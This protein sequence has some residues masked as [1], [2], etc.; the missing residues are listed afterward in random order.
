MTAPRTLEPEFR[1]APA[2][3][4][5]EAA[6]APA[7]P[8]PSR[9]GRLFGVLL[10]VALV[11]AA[12]G[13]FAFRQLFPPPPLAPVVATAP[14][15]AP[16][17]AAAPAAPEILHPLAPP[18][19]APPLPALAES[20]GPFVD[21]LAAAVGRDAI[22]RWLVP[23][24]LIRRIVVAVDNLPRSAVPQK[25]SPAKP[26]P[27]TFAVAGSDAAH[28]IAEANAARY[29]PL[30]RAVEAIDAEKLVAAYRLWYPRFQDAYRE[31]GYPNGYFNDRVVA[32]IDSMLAAPVAPGELPVVQPKVLW[33]FA[34]PNLE[35]RP[36]GQKLMLRIG[37]DNAARVRAKLAAIRRLIA[38]DAP[39]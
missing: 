12:G 10:V 11:V 37:R 6:P 15:P 19:T 1:S 2:L 24:D 20:D 35:A 4:V 27:G 33:E 13:W 17:V 36:A 34:D 31:Q 18:P 5:D 39:H 30:V 14:A 8:P 23:Q 38:R 7:A 32:A 28:G 21:A 25:M 29:V 26:V 9:A 22:A 3:A 16:A